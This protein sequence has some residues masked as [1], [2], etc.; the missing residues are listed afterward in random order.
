MSEKKEWLGI[1]GMSP[2]AFGAAGIEARVC[3]GGNTWVWLPVSRD[4]LRDFL[5]QNPEARDSLLETSGAM[6]TATRTCPVCGGDG[7]PGPYD[8]GEKCH[9]CDGA[10]VVPVVPLE[11]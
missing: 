1:G 8:A 2:M 3:M 9:L 4:K 6:A 10:G 11:D 5:N 7:K